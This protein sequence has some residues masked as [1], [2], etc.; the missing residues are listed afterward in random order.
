MS[1]DARQ[2]LVVD[3]EAA[4][5]R[6]AARMLTQLGFTAV[7]AADGTEAL[8]ILRRDAGQIALVILDLT[9]PGMQV[10]ELLTEIERDDIR[11]PVVICSGHD[12]QAQRQRFAGHRVAGYLQKPY[13]LDN[14]R[15]AVL[16][17]LS[18]V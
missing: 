3:D 9:I 12:A 18:A 4:V 8:A 6:L 5:R 10:D 17:A 13:R 1:P 15:T 11:V 16:A 7:E 14:L 2:V